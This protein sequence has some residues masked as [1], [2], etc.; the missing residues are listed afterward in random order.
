MLLSEACCKLYKKLAVIGLN[1]RIL[2]STVSYNSAAPLAPVYDDKAAAR[3]GQRLY[4]AKYSAAGV[5]AISRIYINVQRA[6]A[7]GTVVS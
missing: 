2:S 5:C 7:E 4:G 1:L 3:V 6:Q